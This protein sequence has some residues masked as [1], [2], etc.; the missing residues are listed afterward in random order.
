M[1]EVAVLLAIAALLIGILTSMLGGVY[2]ILL[3]LG[4]L[5]A[6]V[7]NGLVDRIG[8]AEEWIAWMVKDRIGAAR[9]EG[10]PLATPVP[11]SDEI[12]DVLP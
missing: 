1:S 6:V 12:E 5:E 8:K 3:R 2:V 11:D 9:R 4:R 10:T 7:G